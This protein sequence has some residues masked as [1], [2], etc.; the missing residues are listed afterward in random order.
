MG[1]SNFFKREPCQFFS[2]ILVEACYR[3][4]VP[5]AP[6]MA[7]LGHDKSGIRALGFPMVNG[8]DVL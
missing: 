1:E 8:V 7:G 5:Y 4:K 6:V 3:T 2:K